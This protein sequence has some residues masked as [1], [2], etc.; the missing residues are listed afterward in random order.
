MPEDIVAALN[1]DELIDLVAYLETLKT[2]ALTPDSVPDRRPVPGRE[3]GRGAR[4]GIRPGE[5]TVRPEAAKFGDVI[6]WKTIRPDG[7]GYFDLAALHGRRGEQ[8]GVV[9]VRRDRFAGRSGR[10]NAARRRTTARSCG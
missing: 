2:A 8:L 7:K 6:G 9:H 1:E 3:H 5:G 10:G 4:H